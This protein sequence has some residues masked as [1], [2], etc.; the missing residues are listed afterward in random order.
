MVAREPA[1]I[2]KQIQLRAPRARVWR[3][4]TDSDEFGAWFGARLVGPFRPGRTASGPI[5]TPG[6][7]R[8]TLHLQVERI[9]PQS[10]FSYRWHPHAVDPNVDYSSEPTTLVEFRLEDAAGGGSLLTVIESG[11][12]HVPLARRARAFQMNE[13]GWALQMENIARY[14]AT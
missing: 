12:E 13:G 8:C 14:V 7:E 1:R 5:T 11:F 9:E 2:E 3:A 6:F 10:Y 4:L